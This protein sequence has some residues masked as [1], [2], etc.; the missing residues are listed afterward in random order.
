MPAS[1]LAVS[2]PPEEPHPLSQPVTDSHG[3]ADY[4]RAMVT[5]MTLRALR[6]AAERAA[7][8]G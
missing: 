2:V 6:I 7:R 8:N 1:V 4:K 3:P 5:E